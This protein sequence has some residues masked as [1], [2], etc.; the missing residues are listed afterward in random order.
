MDKLMET[1]VKD[2]HVFINAEF[3]HHLPVNT[4]CIL[5]GIDSCKF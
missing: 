2:T 3:V 4:A 5:R 1:V